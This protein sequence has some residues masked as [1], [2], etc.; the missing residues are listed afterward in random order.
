LIYELN[1]L[2]G[3]DCELMSEAQEHPQQHLPGIPAAAVTP[4]YSH[5]AERR[6]FEEALRDVPFADLYADLVSQ[7]WYWRKAA[8]VAWL[9]TPKNERIPQFQRD[10][11]NLL[12]CSQDVVSGFKQRAEVQAAVMRITTASLIAHKAAV[13]DALIKSASSADYKNNQDRKTFY[14]LIGALKEQHDLTLNQG[15]NAAMQQMSDAELLALAA[16]GEEDDA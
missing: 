1:G 14:Q 7:G 8:V 15:D 6:L 13:D 4:D 10:L 11:A 16:I 5:A 3:F 12:G 2:I 9:A